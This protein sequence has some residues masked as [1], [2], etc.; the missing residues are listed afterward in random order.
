MG[1]FVEKAAYT[2][3]DDGFLSPIMSGTS[4]LVSLGSTSYVTRAMRSVTP[5]DIV[6]DQLSNLY[7]AT[8]DK[9]QIAR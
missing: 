1:L 9:N 4:F 3:T 8:N 7:W 5:H 6:V 2:K